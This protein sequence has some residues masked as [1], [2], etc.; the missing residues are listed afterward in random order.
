LNGDLGFVIR[1]SSY[2]QMNYYQLD[3]ATNYRFIACRLNTAQR[4]SGIFL[5]IIRSLST[6][7]AAFG[8]P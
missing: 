2:I 4:V 5:P 3:A 6:A 1:A 7:A 8:L